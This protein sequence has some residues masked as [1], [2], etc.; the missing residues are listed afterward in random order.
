MDVIQ[1]NVGDLRLDPRNRELFDPVEGEDFELFVASIK[2]LGIINPISATPSGLIIAGEQRHRGAIAAG[3]A[4]VPVIEWDVDD[5]TVERMRIDENL[6]H[7]VLKPSET[8]RAIRRLYVINEIKQGKN[9]SSAK[10]AE[11]LAEATGLTE[12]TI[13]RYNRIANL[14]PELMV[15]LDA[16]QFSDR[17]AEQLGFL[18]EEDQRALLAVWTADDLA[19]ASEAEIRQLRQRA[20]S[21]EEEIQRIRAAAAEAAAKAKQE[22]EARAL[23]QMQQLRVIEEQRRLEALARVRD[24]KNDEI[25]TLHNQIRDLEKDLTA[26][27]GKAQS[28]IKE[29][30]AGKNLEIQHL[31]TEIRKLSEKVNEATYA[32]QWEK[33]NEIHRAIQTLFKWA[34]SDPVDLVRNLNGFDALRVFLEGDREAMQQL[35]PWLQRYDRALAERLGQPQREGIRMVGG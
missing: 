6:R 4:T 29:V 21:L 13:Q 5:E 20:G 27:E 17:V 2:E 34:G 35:I 31:N 9:N 22:A 8:A 1:R 25:Q 26:Y 30:I 32:A 10:L 19:K 16:R 23:E 33:S 7:R 12:R 14:I 24:E 11:E 15:L 3:F 18:P 28:E